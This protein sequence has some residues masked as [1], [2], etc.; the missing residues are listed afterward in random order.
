MITPEIVASANTRARNATSTQ[1][2]RSDRHQ[3]AIRSVATTE[4]AQPL[5][6]LTAAAATA[7]VR[8][9]SPKGACVGPGSGRGA[10]CCC[11]G[12]GG[13]GMCVVRA[14]S[15]AC[16]SGPVGARRM[17]RVSGFGGRAAG[18]GM[19]GSVNSSTGEGT[20]G[21]AA[22]GQPRHGV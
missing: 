21:Q 7:V 9:G 4:V 12:A 20:D 18:L 13:R 3:P 2:R 1:N 17:M 14:S 11:G 15:T 5:T 16:G 10:N 6:M 19:L 8:L 22:L